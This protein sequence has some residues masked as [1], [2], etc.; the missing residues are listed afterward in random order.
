MSEK[1]ERKGDMVLDAI[2]VVQLAKMKFNPSVTSDQSKNLKRR[3]NMPLQIQHKI[4]LSPLSKELRQKYNV[5]SMT[6]WK[7]DE[8][9]VVR[10]HYKGGKTAEIKARSSSEEKAT[11]EIKKEQI[12]DKEQPSS[13]IPHDRHIVNAITQRTD[14]SAM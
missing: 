9:Q 11:V 5:H 12:P 1:W 2:N 14:S 8:V 4:M 10:G 7:D 13:Y 6:I 3:F